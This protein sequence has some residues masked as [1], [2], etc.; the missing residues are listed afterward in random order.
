MYYLHKTK[1][2]KLMNETVISSILGTDSNIIAAIAG[3]IIGGILSFL[4][5]YILYIKQQNNELKNIAKARKINFKHLENS[6]IGHY[7]DLYKN[8]NES[9]QRKMLPEHPLYLDNDLYFSFVQ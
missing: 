7:G 6:D 2:D 4:A 9:I 8:V 3:A 5:Y 1:N